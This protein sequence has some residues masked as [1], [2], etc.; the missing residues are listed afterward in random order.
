M[1]SSIFKQLSKLKYNFFYSFLISIVLVMAEQLFRVSNPLLG[2]NLDFHKVTVQFAIVFVALLMFKLKTVKIIFTTI[3]VLLFFQYIHFNYFGSWTFP[4]EYVLLFSKFTEVI[5][6]FTTILYITIIPTI[7]IAFMSFFIFKLINS[8]GDKRMRIPYLSYILILF[9]L[10]L[11]LRV[12]LKENSKKGARPNIEVSAIVNSI[13]TLGYFFGRIVPNKITGKSGL[14][15]A[16]VAT[17]T[18]DIEDPDINVIVIMGESLTNSVMSLYGEKDIT[19]PNL[20]KLRQDENF[21]YK[22][23]FTSGIV[24]D[25]AL[26]S[27]FN[28]LYE[29]DSTSQIISTN[30]CLFK[31]AKEN[32]FETYFYSAHSQVGLAYIKSYICLNSIDNYLDGTDETDDI[33][34]NSFDQVLVDRLELIDFNKSNFVVLHQIGSHSP[35][36]LRYPEKFDFF[37]KKAFTDKRDL[38]SYKN[39]ILYTD[40]IIADI[41]S[42]IKSKTT[43]PT[44]VFFTS[45]HG[46]GI[47]EHSGHGNLKLTSNYEVPFFVYAINTQNR[48]KK[49]LADKRFVSHYEVAK[50]VASALGYNAHELK[51]SN[52][53]HAICGKDLS[54][55]AGCLYLNINKG[56]IVSQKID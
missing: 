30:T 36:E 4:L 25:V 54:G 31:M 48:Y 2:Y 10:F 39:S 52:N 37:K 18:I 32:G 35:Y 14:E 12:Y 45:D 17:P 50:M 26:P 13:E 42:I 29:P 8:M 28:L 6:T 19:T 24:T 3:L 21:V 49:S 55:V 7:I 51:E 5:D 1:R 15:K 11:P 27:F 56:E 40:S 44:Y 53:R 34:I 20:D 38:S 41:L 23:A 16:L 47:D 43:K 46:E 22:V 9:L 33:K